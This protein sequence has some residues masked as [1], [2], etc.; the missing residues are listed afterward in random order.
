MI[1]LITGRPGIGKSTICSKL[2]TNL[3]DHN[4]VIGGL[5]TPEVRRNNARIGFKLVDLLSGKEEYLAHI[6]HPSSVKVGRYYVNLIALEHIGVAAIMQASVDADV[7]IIDEIG[8]MEIKS[9][10]FFET[11]LNTIT[12]KKSFVIVVHW[13]LK[14]LLINL[15]PKNQFKLYEVT[16]KNRDKLPSIILNDILSSTSEV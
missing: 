15:L 11:L 12:N 7:I 16:V 5:I 14:S 3:K 10:I 9:K 1:I 6:S 2:I 13:R 8:P 4:I